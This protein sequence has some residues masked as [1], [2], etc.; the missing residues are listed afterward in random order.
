MKRRSEIIY[1]NGD[2]EVVEVDEAT[3]CE[4]IEYEDDKIV[5]RIYG[6]VNQPSADDVAQ[7]AAEVMAA[8]MTEE[9]LEALVDTEE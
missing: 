7:T 8:D 2:R 4:I 6:V 9:E 3:E 1:F 5:N